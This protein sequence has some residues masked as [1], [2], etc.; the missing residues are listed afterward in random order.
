MPDTVPFPAAPAFVAFGPNPTGRDFVVGDLHGQIDMLQRLLRAVGFDRQFDRLFALGDLI[1]RGPGSEQLLQ[2]FHDEPA[3]F[4]IR[5]NHEELML[6]SQTNPVYRRVWE[7]NGGD[8]ADDLSDERLAE[9]TAMIEQMPL[10]IELDLGDGRRIGLVHAEVPPGMDWETVKRVQPGPADQVDDRDS[11][12]ESSLLW[13]RRRFGALEQMA[14]NP[15]AEGLDDDERARTVR[16]VTPVD[17]IDLVV[18]GH[19]IIP[20]RR[21]ARSGNVMFLDTGAYKVDGGR[22]TLAEPRAERYWQ[23]DRDGRMRT[24]PDGMPMPH[25]MPLRESYTR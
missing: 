12:L 20:A 21:P 17:G 22:L 15:E 7:R 6:A 16:T 11:N 5:G 19:T 25:A 4:C 2:L 10:V 23:C 14:L 3:M 18:T 24:E 1:D 9:L 13:G 8:W